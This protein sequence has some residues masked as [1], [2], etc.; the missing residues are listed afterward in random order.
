[1]EA[2]KAIALAKQELSS[3]FEPE[4][5]SDLQLEEVERRRGGGWLVKVSFL[6]A[7]RSKSPEPGSLGAYLPLD[8]QRESRFVEINAVGEVVAVTSLRR[9]TA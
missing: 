1:M 3:L 9:L 7:S 4:G 5:I 2:P 8:W 6:R